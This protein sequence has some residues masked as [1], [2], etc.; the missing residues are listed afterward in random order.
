MLELNQITNKVICGNCEETLKEFPEKCVNLIFTSPPYLDLDKYNGYR[1]PKTSKEYIDWF[2]PKVKLFSKIITDNG[3]FLL[4][5]DTKTENRFKNPYI[6]ELVTEI[7]KNTD[8]RLF[9]TLYWS[10]LKGLPI[11][12]RF[13]SKVEP[14]FWFAK[15]KEFKFYIDKFRMPYSEVSLNRM[16]KPIKKRFART[17]IN[18][19]EN[20]YKKWE[21][22]PLGA[23]PSNLIEVSSESQRICNNHVACFPIKLPEKFILGCTDENDIVADFF[24]GTGSTLVAA[25]KN[26]RNFVGIDISQEYVDFSLERLNNAKV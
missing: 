9:E 3:S 16:K 2:I 24:S 25:K 6:Y 15:N 18:Q 8:F 20:L 13:W 7:I 5:I 22:N 1:G 11:R 4:N 19:N 17:E 12:N 14:I 26:N 23:L 21:S 10:K